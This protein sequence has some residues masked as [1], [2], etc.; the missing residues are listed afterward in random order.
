MSSVFLVYEAQLEGEP[1]VLRVFS[2]HGLALSYKYTKRNSGKYLFIE[3][4]EVL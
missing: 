2:T 3:E 4:K 1:K